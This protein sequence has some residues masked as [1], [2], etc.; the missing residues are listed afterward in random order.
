MSTG[1]PTYWPSDRNKIPDLL[2]FAITKGI[3]EVLSHV[4]SNFD[5]S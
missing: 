4:E 5:L 2:D 1:E 3:S